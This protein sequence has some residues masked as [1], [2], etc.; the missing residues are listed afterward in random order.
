MQTREL[1]PGQRPALQRVNHHCGL[2]PW[3]LLLHLSMISSFLRN[4]CRFSVVIVVYYI[5]NNLFPL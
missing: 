1:V 3:R 4:E 2:L 5:F